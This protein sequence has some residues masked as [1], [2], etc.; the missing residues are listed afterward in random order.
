MD[1][2]RGVDVVQADD[3]AAWLGL[4]EAKVS[5]ADAGYIAVESG[6]QAGQEAIEKALALDESL[7]EAHAAFGWLKISRAWDWDGAEGPIKRAIEL[8]PNN[9][10][11]I[12]FAARLA[13]ARGRWPEAVA[14]NKRGVNIDPLSSRIFHN[15]G[16]A[17]YYG[18]QQKEAAAAIRRALELNPAMSIAHLSLAKVYLE[19]RNSQQAM[20]EALTEKHPAYGL[21]AQVLAYHAVGRKKESDAAMEAL[22]AKYSVE[23]AFQI[24]EAYAFRGETERAFEWLERARSQRDPGFSEMKG[25]PLLRNIEPD[26]RYAAFLRKMG[27]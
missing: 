18:G 10:Q 20:A 6:Y 23:D 7:G 1:R 15:L 22:V 5:Q 12:R 27:L 4:G 19:M 2:F 17:H 16:L 8:E 24:A 14:L 3:P 26:P 21:L 25:D 13:R 11:V 9:P